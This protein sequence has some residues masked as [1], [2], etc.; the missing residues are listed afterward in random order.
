MSQGVLPKTISS[1]LHVYNVNGPVYDLAHIVTK[2]LHL[3]LSLDD[4]LTRVTSVPA[5]VIHMP[6][7]IGTLA[8]GAWGD[9]VVMELRQGEFQLADSRGQMRVG[10]QSLVPLTVVKG[11]A[12]YRQHGT[13]GVP[14]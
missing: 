2:F 6:G 14:I 10:R 3:G 13:T 11:G 5:E 8:E 9:A 4:A 12:V 7:Q 1:D